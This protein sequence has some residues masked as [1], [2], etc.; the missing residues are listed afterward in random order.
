MVKRAATPE[1]RYKVHEL[2]WQSLRWVIL[3]S[4]HPGLTEVKRAMGMMVVADAVPWRW[5]EL[6]VEIW[7]VA[8]VRTLDLWGPTSG[9]PMHPDVNVAAVQ[10]RRVETW[11]TTMLEDL[12]GE[13]QR[14]CFLLDEPA[15]IASVREITNYDSIKARIKVWR[16]ATVGAAEA[17]QADLDAVVARLDVDEPEGAGAW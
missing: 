8:A 2:R 13:L 17:R 4:N 10:Q 15:A 5:D 7:L 11:T 9:N 16:A 1:D 12:A 6:K 3:H 14:T